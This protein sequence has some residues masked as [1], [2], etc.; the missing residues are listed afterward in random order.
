MSHK[1]LTKFDESFDK[2]RPFN[3]TSKVP[4]QLAMMRPISFESD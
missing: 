2:F 1:M 3:T 4:N